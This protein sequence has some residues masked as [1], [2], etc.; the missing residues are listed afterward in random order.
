MSNYVDHIVL[1][2]Y[3]SQL[4][5]WFFNSSI[6]QVNQYDPFF[7]ISVFQVMTKT[8]QCGWFSHTCLVADNHNFIMDFP[9]ILF[10]DFKR[11]TSTNKFAQGI[12]LSVG[13]YQNETLI[14]F[15]Q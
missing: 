15:P 13:F 9:D 12:N 4:F 2:S 14:G 10:R 3:F 6:I 11:F 1:F 5:N 8:I 7:L